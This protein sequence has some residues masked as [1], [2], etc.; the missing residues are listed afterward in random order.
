MREPLGDSETAFTLA[1][2]EFGAAD[3]SRSSAAGGLSPLVSVVIPTYGHERYIAATLESVFAQSFLDREIIIVNDGS[4][5]CTARL[6]APFADDRRISYV[7][8]AHA[9]PSAARNYGLQMARGE[10]VAFLDDDDVWP[11]EKLAWQV[12]AMRASPTAVLVYG[13]VE[14]FGRSATLQKVIRPAGRVREN[15][16]IRNLIASPG[17]TLIRRSA[18]AAVGGFDETLWGADDWDLYIRLAAIG[19][20]LYD[21][22]LALRHR[23]HEANA[24]GRAWLMYLNDCRVL[25]KHFGRVPAL[26]DVPA[27]F[28]ARRYVVEYCLQ[29][30]ARSMRIRWQECWRR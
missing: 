4:P 28:S 9:G 14:T 3:P 24:S 26:H 2:C 5:D 18:L 15:F 1:R 30:L 10:F 25:R 12:E 22:R 6:L 7:E 19:E 29:M 21:P 17:Q 11:A 8:Q 20:F 16:R 23:V 13:S 27:W